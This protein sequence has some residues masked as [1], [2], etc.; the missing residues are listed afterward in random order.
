MDNFYD[1]LSRQLA[2]PDY[3]GRNLDAL[4][5]VL[6]ADIKGPV[7]IVWKNAASSKKALGSD[8]DSVVDVL[9]RVAK[10]RED[11]RVLMQ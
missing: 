3:F 7:E 1:E 9:R 8:F 5:D 2:F 11:F 10:E 6:V 4:W